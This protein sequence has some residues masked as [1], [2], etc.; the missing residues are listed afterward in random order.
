LHRWGRDQSSGCGH[1]HGVIL[2]TEM[3]VSYQN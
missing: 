1:K 2:A 3:F